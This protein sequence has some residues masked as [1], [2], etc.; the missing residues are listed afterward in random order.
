[1]VSQVHID[2]RNDQILAPQTKVKT[3]D[4]FRLN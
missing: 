4:H 1:M 2:M 3:S